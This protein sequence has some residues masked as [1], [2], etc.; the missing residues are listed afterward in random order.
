M[1]RA[2]Y[3]YKVAMINNA[4][5]SFNRQAKIDKYNLAA[6]YANVN[7]LHKKGDLIESKVYEGVRIKIEEIKIG[8]S[9]E[10]IPCCI[11]VGQTLRK[12][13]EPTSKG[14]IVSIWQHQIKE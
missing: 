5:V 10:G 1:N 6:D 13:L 2:E 9:S 11:Y 14:G 3:V 4:V 7:N 8:I 12:N